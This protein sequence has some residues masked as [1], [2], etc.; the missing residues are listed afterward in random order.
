MFDD[1]GF[2]PRDRRYGALSAVRLLPSV[3]A[4]TLFLPQ[5]WVLGGTPVLPEHLPWL[6]VLALVVVAGNVLLLPFSWSP[7]VPQVGLLTVT[8]A[9]CGI[10]LLHP[11]GVVYALPFWTARLA[12]RYRGPLSYVVIGLSMVGAGLPQLLKDFQWLAGLG[13]ALG[14]LALVLLTAN[15]Q[16]R[17]ERLEQAELLVAR[18]Q[19]VVEE[20]ARAAAL[21]ERAR[22]A[23]EVH[24]V[25]AHSLAGLSLT[26]QGTR[27]MLQ[28]DNASQEV[29]DQV[30][31]AQKLAADGLAEAR[32]A[33]AALREDKVPDA[34]AIA[35]LVTA[36]RLESGATAELIVNG[37][38]RDLPAEAASALY[39]TAQEALTNA[40]KHAPG[41]PVN[42]VL[43][44]EDGRTVLTVTDHPGKPPAHVTSGGY[45]LLGMRERA[46]LIG[47]ELET[48]PMEDG[49]RVRLVVPA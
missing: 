19:Q 21:A 25:L 34:R 32:R 4:L 45:G 28:R 47:G 12:V 8:L 44:F 40:R 33:V 49:W 15:R 1:Q 10:L 23:R 38:P 14:V 43:D 46:E 18:R 7:M 36:F 42:A 26:L 41:A 2:V 20:H 29:I 37:E 16:G 35:D 5:K 13:I 11:N 3:F 22:I 17:E 27:L 6:I 9:S 39:R 30:T 48:G 31:K 24:D